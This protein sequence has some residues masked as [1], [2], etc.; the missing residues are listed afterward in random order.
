[1]KA[2]HAWTP[3]AGRGRLI[4][5]PSTSGSVIHQMVDEREA[6]CLGAT[7]WEDALD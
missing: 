3:L 7:G 1:M 6:K 5:N 2:A 4:R